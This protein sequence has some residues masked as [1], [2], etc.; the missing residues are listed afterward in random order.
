[1]E[2]HGFYS[3][4]NTKSNENKTNEH[5]IVDGKKNRYNNF[6]FVDVDFRL[7]VVYTFVLN[8]LFESQDT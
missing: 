7:C 5:K 1:M 4:D 6:Y 2:S 8:M 3:L